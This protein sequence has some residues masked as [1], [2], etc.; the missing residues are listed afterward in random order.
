M[1]DDALQRDKLELEC[2]LNHKTVD[3]CEVNDK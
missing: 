1:N 2:P 3:I